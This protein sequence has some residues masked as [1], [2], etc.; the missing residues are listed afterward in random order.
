MNPEPIFAIAN[1]G[2]LIFWLFLI[3]A[4]RWMGTQIAVHSIAIPAVLGLTYV[5]LIASGYMGGMPEGAAISRCAWRW[6][7]AACSWRRRPLEARVGCCR[8]L[9]LPL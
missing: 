6:E 2:I 1:N 9:R 5:W 7:K 3:V 8:R 4:P